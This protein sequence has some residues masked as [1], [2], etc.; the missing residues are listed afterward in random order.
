MPL[1]HV[2]HPAYK[3]THVP[4]LHS[5]FTPH[6]LHVLLSCFM[7]NSWLINLCW[8]DTH[9]RTRFPYPLLVNII[10]SYTI[11]SE[12]L[13]FR[14]LNPHFDTFLI[15]PR[16]VFLPQLEFSFSAVYTGQLIFTKYNQEPD[17]YSSP[18]RH[19]WGIATSAGG[20]PKFCEPRL[21]C[22]YH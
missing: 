3:L 6:A 11:R 17:I 19:A 16:A 22:G 8:L 5:G 21:Y 15:I 10:E 18:A 4:K 14:I 9:A 20:R 12:K 7:C 13:L 1:L 2:M